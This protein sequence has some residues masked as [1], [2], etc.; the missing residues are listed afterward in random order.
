MNEDQVKI[1]L[2]LNIWTTST[3]V[4]QSSG[5]HIRDIGKQCRAISDG[6]HVASYQD[7]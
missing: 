5:Y 3:P 1:I 2:T 6:I 4:A 7:I